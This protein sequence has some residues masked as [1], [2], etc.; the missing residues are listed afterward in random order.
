M[1]PPDQKQRDQ[2]FKV[3]IFVSVGLVFMLIAILVLG[4]SENAFT[5]KIRYRARFD[6][7]A[8]LIPGAKVMLSGITIGTI[9]DIVYQPDTKGSELIFN[10]EKKYAPHIRLGSQVE[11]LTQGVLGDKYLSITP[12]SGERPLNEDELLMPTVSQ[13][14]TQLMSRSDQLLIHLTAAA[15]SL[16]R[17]LKNLDRGDRLASITANLSTASENMVK[18]T[19]D[20]ELADLKRAAKELASILEKINNGT[21]SLGAVINDPELYD[22]VRALIGGANRNRILRNLVRKTAQDATAP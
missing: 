9:S 12:G 17:V 18:M 15:Q 8:G 4:G 2:T 11:V 5:S 3:G 7:A 10:V 21:G 22:D 14:L 6:S 20:K 19:S 1:S 13:D 16:D